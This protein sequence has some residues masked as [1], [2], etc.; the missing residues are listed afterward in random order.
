[1][2]ISKPAVLTAAALAFTALVP[3]AAANAADKIIIG[4]TATAD[5]ASEP[6]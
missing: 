6:R 3:F 2:N 1:M 4:C 5:C